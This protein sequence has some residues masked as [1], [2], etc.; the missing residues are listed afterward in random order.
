MATE[1]S[2][3]NPETPHLDHVAIKG[4][5]NKTLKRW[6]NGFRLG[7]VMCIALTVFSGVDR[8]VANENGDYDISGV[9]RGRGNTAL[10]LFVIC[11]IGN[12][13][14]LFK[15]EQN[16]KK[17]KQL[18]D[19]MINEFSSAADKENI[20]LWR[21]NDEYHRMAAEYFLSHMTDTER[22]N[23][24]NRFDKL[25]PNDQESEYEFM[26]YLLQT[27]NNVMTKNPGLCKAVADIATGKTCVWS[28]ATQR[29][30]GC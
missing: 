10:I 21:S 26:E 29:A 12:L 16:D 30:Y 20:T 24:K 22:N 28:K 1:T 23:L 15:K 9:A 19:A 4:T 13:G 6:N 25:N 8:F 14:T 2:Y 27:V 18:V 5:Q 11:A 3:F 17:R 7:M